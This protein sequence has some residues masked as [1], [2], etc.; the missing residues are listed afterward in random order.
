[1]FYYSSI[2]ASCYL[3]HELIFAKEKFQKK[4]VLT[5]GIC[6]VGMSQIQWIGILA[7]INILFALKNLGQ[8]KYRQLF[9]HFIG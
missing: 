9:L 2:C 3:A 6:A 7:H 5:A 4:P 1:M 8:T